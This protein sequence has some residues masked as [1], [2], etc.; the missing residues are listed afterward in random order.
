[1]DKI[2]DWTESYLNKDNMHQT[3]LRQ[4]EEY[5]KGL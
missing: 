3:C 2:L 5:E 4:I 1:M